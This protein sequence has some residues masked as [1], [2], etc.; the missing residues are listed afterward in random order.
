MKKTI[1]ALLLSALLPMLLTSCFPSGE[2]TG[3]YTMLATVESIEEP[4]SVNVIEAEYAEGIYWLV[5]DKSTVYLDSDGSTI[6]KSH[7]A[8]GDTV[9]ITYNGQVMLSYPAQ[10]FAIRIQKK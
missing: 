6:D 3:G 4:F 7:L 5:T 2:A 9:E 8:P 10:I 1:R